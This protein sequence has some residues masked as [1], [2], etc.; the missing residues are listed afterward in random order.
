MNFNMPR[1]CG[2]CP[3]LKMGAIDLRP[4]RVEGIAAHLLRDDHA[5]FQCHKTVHGPHGGEWDDDGNYCA[6]GHES[7]CM[8]AVA[9]LWKHNRTS[10]LTR[11]AL[12][13]RMITVAQIESLLA[14]VID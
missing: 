3:F 11:L 8:G 1:P 12:A 9:Y 2:N 13:S 7:A 14:E 6:S 5:T 10:I 4:G